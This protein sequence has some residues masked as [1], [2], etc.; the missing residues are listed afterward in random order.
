MQTTAVMTRTKWSIDLV[1]SQIGFK[2]KYLMFSKVRGSFKE[3]D[4]SIYTIGEDFRSVEI[5]FWLNPGSIDTGN[6]QRD[7]HLKN[8]DFFEVEN[9][10]EIN[11][12]ANTFAETDKEDNYELYGELTMKGI[13]KQIK[14]DVEFGGIIKDPWGADKALFSING[15]I[16]RKDWGLNW[17]AA[18]ETGGILVS[19][20]V[21]IDCEAQLIKQP[22]L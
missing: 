19:D 7:A 14:L 2:V 22:Q 1:N 3:F 10:K 11:F 4:A 17:N 13:K 21:W 18:L 5:D 20:E 15:K 8:E 6:A 16:N 12:T 9:F